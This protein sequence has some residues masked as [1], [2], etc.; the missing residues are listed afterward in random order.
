MASVVRHICLADD[1]PDDYYL[2]TSVLR[3]INDSVK[4]SWCNSCENLMEFLHARSDLPDIILMDMNMPRLDGQQ[5]LRKIKNDPQLHHIPVIIYSTAS[6]PTTMKIAYE[7]G[8]YKY[9][10][11][12]HSITELKQIIN[13]LL[14]IPINK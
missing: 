10:M 4:V 9:L 11:K 14:E 3:D 7:Q 5:C 2:F 13:D 6:S 1:D 8:A 12:P